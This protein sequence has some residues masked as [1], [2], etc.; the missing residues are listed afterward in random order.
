MLGFIL[1]GNKDNLWLLYMI[2]FVEATIGTFFTPA[3][4]AIIPSI[5]QTE[6]LLAANSLA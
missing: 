6:G 2:A 1:A 4:S 5:V 3:R